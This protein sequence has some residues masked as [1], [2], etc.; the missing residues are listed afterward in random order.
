MCGGII[1]A[2]VLIFVAG[3]VGIILFAKGG[4]LNP[5]YSPNG[6]FAI[7][8]SEESAVPDF[9][10]G[11]YKVDKDTHFIGL[12]DG[13]T[14]K[15]LWHGANLSGDA[16]ADGIVTGT[17]LVYAANASDLLAY[18]KSDGSQAWQVQMPDKL[19]Y[20]SSSM[21]VT[22]GRVITNNADQSIQAYDAETGSLAWSKRLSGNDNS[23]RLM[24]TSLVVMDYTD[25]NSDYGL[26]FLDPATGAQQNVSPPPARWIATQSI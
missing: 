18:H 8:P 23:L 14:G 24:G 17:D 20:G 12:I 21:L 4:A 3:V 2:I 15:L 13:T 25:S 22:A 1:V 11:L 10:V 6:P 9:A 5:H 16:N 7:I 19:N 26:L